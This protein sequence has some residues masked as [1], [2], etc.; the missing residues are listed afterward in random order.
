[1]CKPSISRGD[2]SHCR[3]MA[4]F[5]N[6][7]RA[8]ERR[9]RLGANLLPVS[10]NFSPVEPKRSFSGVVWT[11]LA[12]PLS[13]LALVVTAVEVASAGIADGKQGPLLPLVPGSQIVVSDATS[14]RRA[15]ENA[16]DNS[17]ILISD[18]TYRAGHLI[19]MRGKKNVTIRG[20]SADP[21]KVLIRGMGWGSEDKRDDILRIGDC[22]NITVAYVTFTDCHGYGIKVEAENHPK[23][24]HIYG[25]HFRDIGTRGIKGSGGHG[26]AK[27]GSIRYCHFENTK[28]PPAHWLFGGNYIAAIDMMALD[29][30]IISDNVFKNIKGRTGSARAAIFVWVRSQNIT[31]QRNLIV[32]CDRGIAFGNP[33]MSSSPV[34]ADESHVHNGICRNNFIVPGPDA[35]IELWWVDGA[36]IYHNT[37]WRPEG[38]GRGIRFG[39]R[40]QDVHIA[41]N[42]V[43][44]A[45]VR[46]DHG[47]AGGIR[48]ENNVTGHLD[49]FFADAPVGDLRIMAIAQSAIDTA[50]PLPEVTDDFHGV[51]RGSRPDIGAAE[52]QAK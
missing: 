17:T 30:W 25:C 23:N 44:G 8:S 32:D 37:I 50:I 22:E 41:N 47:A 10:Q 49:H 43:R 27:L 5:S 39:T 31:V 29:G 33:S 42:L 4:K 15:I 14:L 9:R 20:F 11:K 35:G 38:T 13:V 19:A 28:I 24:I 36:K 16:D 26:S 18:G 1:M 2:T 6:T 3:N 7:R 48:L 40:N 52:R 45:I 46:D 34:T 21:A 12:A 51:P